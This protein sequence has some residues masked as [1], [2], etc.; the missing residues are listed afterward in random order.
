MPLVYRCKNCGRVLHYLERVGQDYVGVPSIREILSRYGY[1][2]PHCKS[3]LSYPSQSDIIITSVKT[4]K[5]LGLTPV[6]IGDHYFVKITDTILDLMKGL[7]KPEEVKE[8]A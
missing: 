1:T 2:C 6:R 7:P 3:R 8:T 5:K 4:A